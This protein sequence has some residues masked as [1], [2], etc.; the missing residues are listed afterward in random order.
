MLLGEQQEQGVIDLR[1][2]EDATWL[3]RENRNLMIGRVRH[4]LKDLDHRNV[5]INSIHWALARNGLAEER[6][7]SQFALHGEGSGQKIVGRV[8]AK[9]LAGDEMG[10]RVYLVVDGIDGRVHHMEFKDPARIKEVAR[11]MIVEAGPA[12]SGPRPGDRNIAANASEDDGLYRPSQHLERV[13]DSLERRGKD[14]EAFVRSHV[15]RLEAL[16]RAGHV[17]RIDAD[18][19][20]IPKDIVGR[21]QAYDLS[22]GGDGLRTDALSY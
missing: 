18:N 6:R 8:L 11:D 9:G 17:E 15:R 14:P 4:L 19:W 20:K 1:P 12:V 21:G 13:R 3:V 10:E 22:Q 16:R 5:V 7:L 2:G